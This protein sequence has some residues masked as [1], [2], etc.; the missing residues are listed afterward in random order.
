MAL[1]LSGCPGFLVLPHH[2]AQSSEQYYSDKGHI[3]TTSRHNFFTSLETCI[4]TLGMWLCKQIGT[5]SSPEQ[6]NCSENV[7]KMAPFPLHSL[8]ENPF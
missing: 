2:V 3:L 1:F 4:Y 7:L 8:K 5:S 6:E